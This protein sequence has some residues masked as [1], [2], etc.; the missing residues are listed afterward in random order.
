M[1]V[2]PQS[3]E[4]G[5]FESLDRMTGPNAFF[6]L[7]KLY[8]EIKNCACTIPMLYM[9]PFLYTVSTKHY[10]FKVCGPAVQREL[11]PCSYWAEAGPRYVGLD[12]STKPARSC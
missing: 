3:N 5:G 4:N 11:P 2:Q 1:P 8:N 9:I 10:F 6:K 7:S 12:R